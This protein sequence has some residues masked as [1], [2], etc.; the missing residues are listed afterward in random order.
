MAQGQVGEGVE[1]GPLQG[2]A[3]APARLEERAWLVATVR[4]L[5]QCSCPV[6]ERRL[7][8]ETLAG[9][10]WSRGSPSLQ[11]QEHGWRSTC[12]KES[13]G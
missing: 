6:G 7:G 10:G 12:W 8:G 5:G 3:G 11:Q 1:S 4:C 13:A 9:G 2:N